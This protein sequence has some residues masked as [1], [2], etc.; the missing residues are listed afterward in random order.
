MPRRVLVL[1]AMLILG[2][3][4][5]DSPASGD[6]IQILGG[7]VTLVGQ[8]TADNSVDIHGTQG[9][10][11][12]FIPGGVG[13]QW[14]CQP[15]G[16]PGTAISLDASLDT[17]DGAGTIEFGGST[18]RVGSIGGSPG[19]AV[20]TLRLLGDPVILPPMAPRATLS[21]PFELGTSQL[22][23]EVGE[24]GPAVF[25]ITGRGTATLEVVPNPFTEQ[26][27]EL[28]SL[29]YDFAPVPEPAT[30][31]LL[32]TGM[33]TLAARRYRHRTGSGDSTAG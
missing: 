8:F 9:F 26:L 21:A 4:L 19:T 22:F 25:S 13:G 10:T 16:P 24:P 29:R 32:G 28:S 30:L 17:V 6:P 33:L 7:S 11:A 27:W 3:A 14:V 23:L 15:C 20:M 31:L 12:K 18:Y 5:P 2:M 1:P